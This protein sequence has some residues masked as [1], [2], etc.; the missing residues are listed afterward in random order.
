VV[1]WAI[2]RPLSVTRWSEREKQAIMSS[3]QTE[4]I[5]QGIKREKTFQI[6]LSHAHTAVAEISSS[7]SSLPALLSLSFF[8]SC[9]PSPHVV[10]TYVSGVCMCASVLGVWRGIIHNVGAAQLLLFLNR[11]SFHQKEKPPGRECNWKPQWALA[12]AAAEQLGRHHSTHTA[13]AHFEACEAGKRAS[14]ATKLYLARAAAPFVH[15]IECIMI[16]RR[17]ICNELIYFMTHQLNQIIEMEQQFVP[18][19]HCGNLLYSYFGLWFSLH[20][21][22]FERVMYRLS[23]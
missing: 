4:S 6:E 3:V 2:I 11:I 8:R 13:L 23:T 12:A 1:D 10:R 7:S 20:I 9:A 17:P 21:I 18:A 5:S 15:A 16:I 14:E 19:H 22:W